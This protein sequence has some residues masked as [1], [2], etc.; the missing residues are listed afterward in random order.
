MFAGKDRKKP[1]TLKWVFDRG[2]TNI[3]AHLNDLF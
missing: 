2:L 1:F 3:L